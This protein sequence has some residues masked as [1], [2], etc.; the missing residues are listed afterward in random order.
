M[1]I[2]LIGMILSSADRG[3]FDGIIINDE[4]K[5]LNAIESLDHMIMEYAKVRNGGTSAV[6]TIPSE[7]EVPA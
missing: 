3:W 1:K 5:E 4:G 7:F 6:V 2:N